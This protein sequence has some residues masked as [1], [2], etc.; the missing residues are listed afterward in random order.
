MREY[1]GFLDERVLVRRCGKE[2]AGGEEVSAMIWGREP[3]AGG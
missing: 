2:V 3:G 1:K